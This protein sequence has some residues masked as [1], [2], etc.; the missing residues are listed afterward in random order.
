MVMRVFVRS[1]V[2]KNWSVATFDG[3]LYLTLYV[4]FYL[5]GTS[6]RGQRDFKLVLYIYLYYTITWNWPDVCCKV[7]LLL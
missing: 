7:H 1:Q 2:F 4:S 5:S 3:I 6:S